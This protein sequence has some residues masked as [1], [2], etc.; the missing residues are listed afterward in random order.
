M[1][2]TSGDT[3]KKGD[4][5]KMHVQLRHASATA[6][7]SY[8]RTAKMWSDDMDKIVQKLIQ[9]CAFR[10]AFPP[11]T[12]SKV[13][14]RSPR[15]DAQGHVSLEVVHLDGREF[16]HIM[17]LV[18]RGRVPRTERHGHYNCSIR[19]YSEPPPWPPK[20]N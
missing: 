11:M 12:H 3:L 18:V 20:D 19:A 1:E 7:R 15:T 16:L 17:Y 2:D 5:K 8:I 6:P 14:K 13:A 9:E 10:A 4:I